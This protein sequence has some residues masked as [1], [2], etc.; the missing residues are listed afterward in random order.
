MDSSRILGNVGQVGSLWV[1]HAEQIGEYMAS[2]SS[3][4][5]YSIDP[6]GSKMEVDRVVSKAQHGNKAI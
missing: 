5:A 1:A 4:G 2:I 6:I 3:E